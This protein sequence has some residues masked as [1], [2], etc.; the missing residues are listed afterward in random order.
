VVFSLVRFVRQPP[1][2][3][4][5]SINLGQL[6]PYTS[7][8]QTLAPFF[9]GRGSGRETMTSLAPRI[10]FRVVF[11]IEIVLIEHSRG[12]EACATTDLPEEDIGRLDTL[13]RNFGIGLI[14]F[15][16][17]KAKDPKFEIRAP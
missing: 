8:P 13:G 12:A 14:L 6:S 1:H 3:A 15:D 10:G 16:A 11:G 2:K 7:G 4:I 9:L 17:K 5:I